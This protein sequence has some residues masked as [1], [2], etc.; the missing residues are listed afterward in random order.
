MCGPTMKSHLRYSDIASS[1]PIFAATG[2][3][4]A[5]AMRLRCGWPSKR[6]LVKILDFADALKLDR[7]AVSGHDWGGVRRRSR[8]RCIRSACARRP[9]RWKH[10]FRHR[11]AL[12]TR[13]A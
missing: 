11:A 1:S 12:A 13:F 9:H 5:S 10:R 2:L 6:L 7:F 3:L 8:R 4:R